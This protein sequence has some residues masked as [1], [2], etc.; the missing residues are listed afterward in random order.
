MEWFHIHNVRTNWRVGMSKELI[1]NLNNSIENLSVYL[2][3]VSPHDRRVWLVPTIN[4]LEEALKKIKS[5]N[6]FPT[7]KAFEKIEGCTKH[8][9]EFY[10]NEKKKEESND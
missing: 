8:P 4:N 6:G 3:R 7:F 5:I 1:D 10:M 9:E 2:E